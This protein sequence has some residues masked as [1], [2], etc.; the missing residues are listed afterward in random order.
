MFAVVYTDAIQSV[1]MIVGVAITIAVRPPPPRP[2]RPTPPARPGPPGPPARP[3]RPHG[4]HCPPSLSARA[5]RAHRP[6]AFLQ[7]PIALP[8]LS[9]SPATLG[10]YEQRPP[11]RMAHRQVASW[12][13]GGVDTYAVLRGHAWD[14]RGGVRAASPGSGGWLQWEQLGQLAPT[15]STAPAESC[16]SPCT[17]HLPL[18]PMC[19]RS[20]SACRRRCQLAPHFMGELTALVRISELSNCRTWYENERVCG[21]T[22]W[23]L[24]ER[25]AL[26]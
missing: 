1:A 13:L 24:P 26:P 20:Q 7:L 18:F 2:A 17:R 15:R 5:P 8:P 14:G 10:L 12:K 3:A 6:R 9:P 19:S 22:Q 25:L 4:P 23:R 16:A 21:M 11:Y